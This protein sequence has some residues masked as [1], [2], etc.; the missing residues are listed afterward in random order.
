MIFSE[1][2]LIGVGREA[3]RMA[4]QLR[5]SPYAQHQA[6]WKLFAR[7]PGSQRPFL[8]REAVTSD[9]PTYWMLSESAPQAGDLWSARSRPYDPQFRSGDRLQFEL[10]ANPTIS[11]RIQGERGKRVD[12]IGERLKDLPAETRAEDRARLVS[13]DLPQ[14]LR[15]RGV[16]NGFAL[17]DAADEGTASTAVHYRR[18]RFDGRGSRPLTL[19]VAEFCGVL[20][21]TDA[22]AFARCVREGLGHGKGFGLGMWMLRRHRG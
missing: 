11:R 6:L 16:R 20:Q 7:E 22:E 15:D 13:E 21:V 8:F 18:W 17:A 10:R 9:A 14:W 5:A 2:K 1:L 3:R 19:G 12:L 4:T